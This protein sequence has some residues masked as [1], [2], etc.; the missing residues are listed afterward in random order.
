MRKSLSLDLFFTAI[1]FSMVTLNGINI[2]P[3]NQ[4][5]YAHIFTTNETA[6]FVAFVYQLQVESE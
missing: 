3:L 4:Y 1:L 6:L 2:N 5:A